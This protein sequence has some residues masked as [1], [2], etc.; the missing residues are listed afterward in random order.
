MIIFMLNT[1]KIV[2]ISIV[3]IA[4]LIV[5]SCDNVHRRGIYYSRTDGICYGGTGTPK[6]MIQLNIT[7]D[8]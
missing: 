7:I 1:N 2:L 4:S 8:G 6:D 5:V 3:A